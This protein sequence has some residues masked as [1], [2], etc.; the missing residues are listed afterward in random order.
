MEFASICLEQYLR[1]IWSKWLL[2][3]AGWISLQFQR[4]L[5]FWKWHEIRDW[6]VMRHL[7]KT[8]HWANRDRFQHWDSS[9]AKRLN[10]API[11]KIFTFLKMARNS[12]LIHHHTSRKKRTLSEPDPTGTLA[13]VGVGCFGPKSSTWTVS[14]FES[15][16]IFSFSTWN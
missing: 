15:T 16:K 12:G 10:F 13:A 8:G 9:G 4:F 6:F 3:L 2:S 11:S 5:P 14:T 1:L 7:E